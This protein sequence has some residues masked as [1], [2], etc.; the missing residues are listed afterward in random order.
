[1]YKGFKETLMD[2]KTYFNQKFYKRMKNKVD[3]SMEISH[4]DETMVQ[5]HQKKKPCKK[6]LW[7]WRDWRDKNNYSINFTQVNEKE[8]MAFLKTIVIEEESKKIEEIECNFNGKKD[9]KG[10]LKICEKSLE[11]KSLMGT[12]NFQLIIPY[13]EIMSISIKVRIFEKY[14]AIET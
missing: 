12:S 8:V 10:E 14:I 3:N 13:T 7:L 1:V 11:F 2:M 4:I 6:E 9:V 5:V